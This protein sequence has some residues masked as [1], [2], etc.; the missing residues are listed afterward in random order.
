MAPK[1]RLSP[2]PHPPT[3]PVFGN[4]LSLDASAPLQS[5]MR[6]AR[7][8]GPIFW[9]DM[10][11]MPFV[12]VSG[13]DLV[14]ELSDEKRFDKLV[15]GSLRRIRAFAGDGLFT[16]HTHEANWSKA[17]NILMTPFGNRAS[18]LCRGESSASSVGPR[19]G[20][21]AKVRDGCDCVG[22][23]FRLCTARSARPSSGSF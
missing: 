19:C 22:R 15:R 6:M 9:L 8:L 17:H 23:S 20:T 5:L 10:M 13:A 18:V 21:A 4:A 7:E 3:K 12:V 11:G 1:N 16:A 2:I 14:D